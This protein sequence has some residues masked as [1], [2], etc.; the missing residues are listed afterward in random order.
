MRVSAIITAAGK[1]ERA[2]FKQNK[3]FTPMQN[4]KTVI[5]NT[6]AAFDKNERVVEIILTA[7]DGEE[8]F[9]S[10]V[11]E[12][13]QTPTLIVKGGKTRSLS[14]A[15]A[16]QLVTGDV[17]LVHDG[18]RP[19][20]SERVINSCIDGV[21]QKGS[22]VAAIE[23]VDTIA[24]VDEYGRIL[25]SSRADRRAVQTPQGFYT[26][27]LR[28][29]IKKAQAAGDL[30]QFTDES[31]LYCKYVK[32][33]AVCVG[34]V[35]N[36]KLTYPQDFDVPA[37]VRAG[38]GYDVHKLVENRKLILGGIEIPHDKGLLGHSDA[39]VLT[40]AV[41]DSLL[42]AC[43]LRD[44]GFYFSD[45]NPEYAGISSMILLEKVMQLIKAEGYKPNNISAVV[46]A[47]KPKLSPFVPL[48]RENLAKALGIPCSAV[49]ISCTT[50]EGIG[51]VGREEGIACTAFCTVVK[52]KE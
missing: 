42:S 38:T 24:E 25:R 44:I 26:H 3:L 16:M 40:H 4:G 43:A 49:G 14:V 31:G 37:G 46:Q 6:L 34:D 17:V 11:A 2:G 13:I 12:A 15:N 51:F 8:D 29:A 10:R 22:A 33:A 20:V 39:D 30:E 32:A 48:V 1:G 28:E 23:C 45:K 36:I 18:A 7:A 47:Q 27:E 35:K 41:M 5:E 9:L 19:F 52:I 50:T 21:E